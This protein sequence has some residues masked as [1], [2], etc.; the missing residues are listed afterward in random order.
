MRNPLDIYSYLYL[1]HF[2]TEFDQDNVV[3]RWEATKYVEYRAGGVRSLPCTRVRWRGKSGA[4]ELIYLGLLHLYLYLYWNVYELHCLCILRTKHSL[5]NLTEK[6]LCSLVSFYMFASL[7]F[8]EC[9]HY[10][11]IHS[12]NADF[13]YV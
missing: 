10:S 4:K 5:G 11:C 8:V 7:Q 1:Y 9:I 6:I 3:I 13:L 12:S 2:D